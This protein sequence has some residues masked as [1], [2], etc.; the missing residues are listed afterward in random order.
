MKMKRTVRLAVRHDSG[1]T[2]G[3]RA[4]G[5][6]GTALVPAPT[7][8]SVSD[9]YLAADI[10]LSTPATI[11]G[12]GSTFQAPLE[13]AA[14][15]LY[16]SR[17]PMPRSTATRPSARAPA[18]PTSS[19]SSSTGAA[20][21][22][23]WPRA[24]STRTSPPAPTT[25][26]RTSSRSRSASAAWRSPSTSRASQVK[27]LVLTASVLANIYLGKITQWNS[28][29]IQAL[30]PKVKLPQTRIIVVARGD[31]SGTTYIFTNFLHAAAPTVWT[32]GPA[33][34]ALTLPPDGIAGSGNAGVASDIENTP[35][36]IGYVEYSYVLLNPSLLKG[37]A[38]IVNKSG[39]AVTPSIAG[40]SLAAA[41][42]PKISA[43]G[44][45]IVFQWGAK[46][47][48]IAGYTWAVIWKAQQTSQAEGTLLVKYLDWLSHSGAV[49]G[50]TAGQDVA[51]LQG[52]VPLPANIQALA[53]TTLLT[54]HLS[55]QGA[56]DHERLLSACMVDEARKLEHRARPRCRPLLWQCQTELLTEKT[57]VFSVKSDFAHWGVLYG[58]SGLFAVICVGLPPERHRLID[59]RLATLRLLAHLRHEPGARRATPSGRS[60]SSPGTLATTA[61]ALIFAIPIGIGSALAIV[62]LLP[63]P[64]CGSSP[65]RSSSSSPPCRASSTGSGACSCSPPGSSRPSSR[66]WPT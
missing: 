44:F 21:T 16:T 34:T 41:A 66:A 26:C 35:N 24:T 29:A 32:T 47:Y 45:S 18:R 63:E 19:R 60:R 57:K 39:D 11:G 8:K 13:N 48:P 55:R 15:A 54:V 7:T 51:A 5:G 40:I 65:P 23:P 31:S 30:N 9:P 27:T 64:G 56:T 36:S 50:T 43:T 62:H 61:I 37:V 53:R 46:T 33:K 14:Q 25:R 28:G 2:L 59:P 49:D 12:A 22:C 6:V 4:G 42:R 1:R 17:N 58:V 52:Y 38:A 10:Q 20:P 3:D